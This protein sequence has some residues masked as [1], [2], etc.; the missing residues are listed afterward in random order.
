MKI[1]NK[2]K[3]HVFE[4]LKKK[5]EG[6]SKIRDICYDEFKSQEYL[7][8]HL[9]NNHEVSLLFSLRSRTA[10]QFK[11][12]FP[13]NREQMCPIPGCIER[14]TQ[15]HC[16]KCEQVSTTKTHIFDVQYE[17]IFSSDITKQ[18]AVTKMFTSLLERRE[19]ANASQPVGP[20]HA[21]S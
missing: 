7:K 21:M 6:H 10:K 16:L 14:D 8:T 12:N 15:E 5:Q 18:V 2:I 4:N 17:D 20:D 13:F 19:D 9:L 11:A 3:T 1:K